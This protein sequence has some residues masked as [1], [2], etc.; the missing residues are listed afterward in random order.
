MENID[1][2]GMLQTEYKCEVDEVGRLAEMFII[3]QM[4][5]DKCSDKDFPSWHNKTS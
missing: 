1:H 4:Q 3:A 5:D 2:D